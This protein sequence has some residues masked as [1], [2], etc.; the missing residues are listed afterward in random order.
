[1]SSTTIKRILPLL[2]LAAANAA[3][4][5]DT[6]TKSYALANLQKVVASSDSCTK[7]YSELQA[8]AK[9]NIVL[10][11]AGNDKQSEFD[12]KHQGE[13]LI[14]HTYKIIQQTA[15]DTTISRFGMGSFELDNNK[16]DY[17]LQISADLNQKN[18]KYSYPIIIT[19]EKSH[20]VFTGLLR[21]DQKT[22]ADFKKNILNH[23]VDN[24]ADLT[25]D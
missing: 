10:Q 20:C 15:T 23:N 22:V 1:M 24:G 18:Q 7:I 11:Y 9:K 21:P 13:R 6:Q 16:M 2:L 3:Y 25:S 14:N 5:A 4:A 17:V 8:L 19:N 12:V